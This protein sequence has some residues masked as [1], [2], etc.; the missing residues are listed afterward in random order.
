LP[1]P[2]EIKKCAYG[3]FHHSY[4]HA[5]KECNSFRRQIQ[6]NIN[7]AHLVLHEMQ[8]DQN[9]FPVNAFMNT[10]ELLNPKVL[11]R[12]DQAN[13]GKGKNIIIGE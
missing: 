5:T 9:L 4:F 11:I 7:E 6:S 2:D 13:E 12:P 10:H 8:V 1:P 3:K